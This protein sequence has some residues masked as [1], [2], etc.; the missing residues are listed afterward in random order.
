MGHATG[1]TALVG[2]GRNPHVVSTVSLGVR[3][4]VKGKDVLFLDKYLFQKVTVRNQSVNE[5]K[6]PN[7]SLKTWLVLDKCLPV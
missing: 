6:T 3:G 2:V 4:G 7:V 5:T 1:V